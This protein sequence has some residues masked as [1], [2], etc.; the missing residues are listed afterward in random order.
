LLEVVTPTPR[1]PVGW[2][3]RPL[4]VWKYRELLPNH[5]ERRVVTLGE[6]GT[7]LLELRRLA[8]S[9]GVRRLRVKVEGGNPTGSFKDRG[10]T[11]A[12]SWAVGD[13]A[14]VLGCASTGN[15]SASMAAYAARAGV[16]GVVL[17][18]AGQVALGKIAQAVAHGARVL[19]IDGSFDDAMATVLELAAAGHLA[20]LNSKNPVRLEG[21]KTLMFEI[22]DQVAQAPE[23]ATHAVPDRV[24]YPVGNAGN[25]SAAHKAL[26][27]YEDAGLLRRMPRLT[28]VQA[29]GASPIAKAIAAGRDSVEDEPQPETIATAIRI[30]RPVSA[31]KALRAIRATDGTAIAVSDDAIT[32][33]QRD[34]ARAGVFCE[35]ASAASVAGLRALAA[36]GVVD[37]GEDVVCVLTGH[38]LKDPAA[39]DRLAAR[40]VRVAARADAILAALSAGPLHAR[41]VAPVAAR[42]A[43]AV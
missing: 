43:G 40:P 20:L 26:V 6:G 18:P 39:A 21:Q 30:G 10:M 12:V 14:K 9:I 41:V 15:T 5:A 33:A 16:A 27:E 11:C 34:L 13:G 8:A 25:I 28:G 31:V 7:Q 37:K 38:G 2:R 24:V 23:G 1:L 17:L 19:E 35:P 42:P 3:D 22:L 36:A 32:A 4:S 29:T